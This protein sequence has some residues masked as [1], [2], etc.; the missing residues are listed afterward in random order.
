MGQCLNG[1]VQDKSSL[2]F[3]QGHA[4]ST[5]LVVSLFPGCFLSPFFWSSYCFSCRHQD[6][7]CLSPG[8]FCIS[9][10]GNPLGRTVHLLLN[11]GCVFVQFHAGAQWHLTA[12]VHGGQR[13]QRGLP[14]CVTP[15]SGHRPALPPPRIS[16]G[17]NDKRHCPVWPSHRASPC[18]AGLAPSDRPSGRATGFAGIAA[19]MRPEFCSGCRG[20]RGVLVTRSPSTVSP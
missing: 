12:L 3:S 18:W 20:C 19:T 6:S 15:L 7:P 2:A 11:L 10:Q 8:I 4:P 17:S 14:Q 16:A 9:P 13:V 1:E 5:S